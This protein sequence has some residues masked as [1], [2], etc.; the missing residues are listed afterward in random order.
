MGLGGKTDMD[1]I[2][3]WAGSTSIV[4]EGFVEKPSERQTMVI[5][6]TNAG[7]ALTETVGRN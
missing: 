2:E 1:M 3:R 5:L 6:Q 4:R 7:L